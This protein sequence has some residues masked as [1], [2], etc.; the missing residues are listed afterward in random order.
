M[1]FLVLGLVVFL[2][3][4]SLRMLA[5]EW[6]SAQVARLGEQKW[7]GLV[8]LV[9]IAGFVLLVWGFGQARMA[10]VVVWDPPAWTR[11]AASLLLLPAFVLIV[12]GNVRGTRMKAAV[13]HPMVLGTLLWAL[14]HLMATRTLADV[15]LFGSFL[16]WAL[17]DFVAARRRDR[18]AGTVYPP[19]SLGRDALVV[20]IG[21]V[22][23]AVFGYWLHGWLIGVRP[24]G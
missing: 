9:A 3:T 6:R 4:H 13:G 7:K 24:I 23:W 16:A 18:A 12:A 15:V 20:A 8:S 1:T 5:G 11:G 10:T 2:G 21:A 17:V 22:A 14:A 19:G